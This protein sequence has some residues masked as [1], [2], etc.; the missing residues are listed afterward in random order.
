MNLESF[1]GLTRVI[2][3]VWTLKIEGKRLRYLHSKKVS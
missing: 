2:N 1:E 3:K